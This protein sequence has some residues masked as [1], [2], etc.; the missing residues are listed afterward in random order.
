[1]NL[2]IQ[3]RLAS[4]VLKCGENAVWLD[5]DQLESI[6]EAST[7]EEIRE[8]IESGAIKRK[9]VKGVSRARARKR[10]L[11]RKKGRRRGHGRRKGRKGARMS[12]KRKWIIRIRALRRRLKELKVEGKLDTRTYRM[13][14]RKAKG[15]EFRSVAHLELYIETNNLLR[16]D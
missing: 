12:R 11:Q 15:G 9:P 8:L 14:Y 7:K 1:M 3:R 5:P 6:A 4:S 10:A 16:G 2:K 13:L